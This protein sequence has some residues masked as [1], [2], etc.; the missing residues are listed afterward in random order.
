MPYNRP[1]TLKVANRK[2]FIVPIGIL[3]VLA[4]VSALL[5]PQPFLLTILVLLLFVA[6]WF[7]YILDFHKVNDVKL[8][9]DI[10]PDGRVRLE[11]GQEPEIIGLL[12]GQQWCTHGVAILRI[13]TQGKQQHL[14]VL[15]AQQEA[16]EFRQLK[17]W[18]RQDFCSDTG[19]KQVSDI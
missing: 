7:I 5:S 4:V 8:I 6:G 11:S 13:T 16:D 3:F 10:F 2:D 9:L 12:S 15:S 17:V 1:L 19:K 18:L 14:A